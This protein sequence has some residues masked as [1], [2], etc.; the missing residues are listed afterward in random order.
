MFEEELKSLFVH[1]TKLGIAANESVHKA[2]KAHN[3][4]DKELA[5]E[6]FADDLRINALTVEIE[7]E[8]FRI[9][10]LQQ[11]VAS[12]LRLVFTVLT[13]SLDIERIADHAVS[14]GRAVIR[15]QETE[16]QV[17]Q[18][19]DVVNRMAETAQTMISD[20][21][22]AFVNRDA[23]TAR[24]VAMLDEV[25]DAGLKEI[26]NESARRMQKNTEMVPSG[27]SYINIGNSLERIGDYVTNICERIVYLNTGEIIELNK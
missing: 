2:I 24:K 11:P 5:K 4:S 18:L 3:T 13:A 7:K 10:A 23:A 1:L 27:I 14:I 19:N 26:Y 25:V 21:M 16:Q 6:L 20:A 22:D 8:A 17:D 15:R 9:I 12:D